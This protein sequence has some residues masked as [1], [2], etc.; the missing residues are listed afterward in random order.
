MI[1][2]KYVRKLFSQIGCTIWERLKDYMP[3]LLTATGL[4]KVVARLPQLRPYCG[5][6]QATM[7][8]EMRRLWTAV[9]AKAKS[10]WVRLGLAAAL[11]VFTG[12]DSARWEQCA[13]QPTLGEGRP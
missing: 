7:S 4:P 8:S 9:L 3:E 10:R 13:L 2:R 1:N 5:A 12:A 11:L 6:F